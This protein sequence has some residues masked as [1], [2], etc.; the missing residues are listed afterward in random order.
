MYDLNISIVYVEEPQDGWKDVYGRYDAMSLM[1][2]IRTVQ[3]S[4]RW[5]RKM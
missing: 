5:G 1:D 4:N 2:I 3:D